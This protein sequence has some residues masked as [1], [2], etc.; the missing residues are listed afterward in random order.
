MEENDTSHDLKQTTSCVKD[1]GR[2]VV[3]RETGSPL[4]ID[5]VTVDRSSKM[6]S[7]VY[8]DVLSAHVHLNRRWS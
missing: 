5:Y 7:E 8:G 2:K 4:V 6:N 1:G 3:T